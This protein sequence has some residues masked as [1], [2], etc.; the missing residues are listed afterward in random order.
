MGREYYEK[1][2]TELMPRY[3]KLYLSRLEKNLFPHLGHIQIADLRRTDILPALRELEGRGHVETAHRV[4]IIAGQ[5]CRYAR[6]C[7]LVEY[8]VADELGRALS[9]AK[10]SQRAAILDPA[11]IGGLL[12]AIDEYGGD[13]SMRYALKIMPY[14]FVRSAELRGARWEEIDFDG[15]T[16]CIPAERMKRRR[17]H[18]VPLAS[19][20]VVLF[21][22]LQEFTDNGELCFPSPFSKARAISDVGL[23]N[24]L[25][26]LGYGKG[27]MDIHGFRSIA[28][29]LLNEQGF[30][31]DVIEMQL[32]H[33]QKDSTRAAYNRALYLPERIGMMQ[34]WADYLDS[35]KDNVE[36]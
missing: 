11:K 4:A 28:S 26:R 31:P 19:Q 17:E 16:W 20:V 30:R 27:E 24:G 6:D 15:R 7:G 1:M 8:N 32:S 33:A 13:I 5:V 9:K 29:T 3:R 14:V 10:H 2:T 25:R 18:L 22:E 35:L 12:R 34:K 23:L 36:P 21:K